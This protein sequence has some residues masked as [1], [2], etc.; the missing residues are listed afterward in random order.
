MIGHLGQRLMKGIIEAGEVL[1]VGKDRLRESNERQRLRN[2]QR[3]EVSSGFQLLKDLRR[4]ALMRQQVRA[5]VDDPMS[6]RDRRPMEVVADLRGE[7]RQRLEL[8]FVDA[9]ALHQLRHRQRRGC[10][11]RHRRGRCRLRCR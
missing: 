8:R 2:M 10:A 7:R 1:R 11:E 6:H 4:D 3:R 9:F 5:T